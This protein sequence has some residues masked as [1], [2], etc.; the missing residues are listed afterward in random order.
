MNK[1]IRTLL[2]I[3]LAI[4]LLFSAAYALESSAEQDFLSFFFDEQQVDAL[5]DYQKKYTANEFLALKIQGKLPTLPTP[6]VVVS[7]PEPVV[8]PSSEVE[9]PLIE[10]EELV[11]Q[12][13]V[14]DSD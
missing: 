14:L 7:E 9:Q 5:Q 3:V 4:T 2:T 12:P 11:E 1:T 10:E 6:N 8:I 13:L